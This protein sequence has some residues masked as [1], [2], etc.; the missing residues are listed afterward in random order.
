[1]RM[2]FLE[3]GIGQIGFVVENIDKAVR[4]YHDSFGI[5][6][7]KIYTYGPDLLTS[8]RRHGCPSS[9]KIRIALSYFGDSRI[10]LIQHLEG[11][12]VYLEFIRQ[13]GF[14]VH[15][16]G[17]YVPDISSALEEARGAGLH[18]MME[19]SGFGLDGDGH[20]A[21]LDTEALFGTTY[22]LIQRPLRRREPESVY[23]PSPP[24]GGSK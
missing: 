7:W 3:S 20:F 18:V 14:G 21:Y 1:M 22:E 6:D 19:G 4:N 13:H 23:P 17:I 12:T 10:E 24:T 11:D 16:L 2:H 15:H 9:Y 5:G 8:M